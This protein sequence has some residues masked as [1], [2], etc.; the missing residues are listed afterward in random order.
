MTAHPKRAVGGGFT[1]RVHGRVHLRRV[2]TPVCGYGRRPVVSMGHVHRL[3][4]RHCPFRLMSG[5]VR[6]NTGCVMNVGGIASGRPFFRKR[7]PRRPMVPNILR[8]RT[9]T[10]VKNLLILGSMSR[11]G[12]CSAC[13]VGVSNIGFHRG[14][15]PNSALVFHMR[16]LTPVHHNVS[17]VGKCTFMNRGM[18]Y[19]TRFVTRVMGGGWLLG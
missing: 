10:R 15:I 11:P 18:M 2:R 19:R 5:I 9:V 16:L 4:P 17:A 6:V 8:V 13:F 1:H 12:H 7:F 14:M 3:L